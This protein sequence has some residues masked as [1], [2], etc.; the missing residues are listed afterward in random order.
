M[1][2]ITQKYINEI[3]Y[4][5][6]GCAIAVH[7][8]LGP[9]LLESI[10]EE[11]FVYECKKNGLLVERQ[12]EIPVYYN[13]ELMGKKFRMDTLI[14]NLIVA[15]LKACDGITP[16]HQAQVLSHM[17]LSKYPKGLL[18]NFNVLNLVKE[19]LI[20]FVNKYFAELPIE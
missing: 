6:V 8:E 19:G 5:T 20:P 13:G 4:K 10:Y 14:E 17:N 7:K 16:M 1:N 12:K 11:C 18:I 2:L 9:G 3:A 15:E